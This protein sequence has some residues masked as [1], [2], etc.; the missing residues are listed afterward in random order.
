MD[1]EHAKH[2]S[3]VSTED[4]NRMAQIMAVGDTESKIFAPRAKFGISIRAATGSITG[5]W[6][7]YHSPDK[8]LPNNEWTK[9]HKTAFNDNDPT[10]IFE[11]PA[12]FWCKLR[13]GSGSNLI[14]HI[15]YLPA[16][17]PMGI[18]INT[19]IES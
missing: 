16:A 6:F 2:N 18:N 14:V 15:E 3:E 19:D 4:K 1:T 5:D 7:L 13:G 10:G 8:S 9:S 17:N 11:I 12:G